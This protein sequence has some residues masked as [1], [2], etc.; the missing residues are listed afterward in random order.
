MLL[1]YAYVL[2]LFKGEG[3]FSAAGL[4]IA[5]YFRD[6]AGVGE[7]SFVFFEKLQKLTYLALAHNTN[8]KG[9]IAVCVHTL[10]VYKRYA[11]V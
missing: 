4:E 2:M 5:V 11:A 6:F 1:C 10:C 7:G 9:F 3:N 8:D